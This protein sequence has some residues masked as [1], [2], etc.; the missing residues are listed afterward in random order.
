MP[1]NRWARRAVWTAAGVLGLWA[2]TWAAVPPLLKWQAQKI[3]SAQLGRSVTIGQVDFRPWSLELTLRDVAVAG[4]NGAAPQL[5]V[6]RAYVDVAL[7]SLFRLA[8]VID[9]IQVDAPIVRLKHLGNGHYDVDDILAKFAARPPAADTGEPARFALYNIQVQ[10]GQI[11][12]DDQ[13]VGRQ[14]HVRDLQLSVPFISNL[15][16]QRQVQV[17][18]KLAFVAN[19][20]PFDSSAHA[21]PFSD[22]RQ[23]DA[24][25]RFTKLDLAPYLGYLPAGLPIRLEAATL[26][27]DL[28]LG[29]EQTPKPSLR[30]QGGL[31]VSG[32]K[33]KDGQ[34]ADAL[35]FDGLKVQLADVRPLEGKLHLSS[36][37]LTNPHVAVRRD[38]Q[39]RINL[40]VAQP[41]QG[42]SKNIAASAGGEGARGT[43]G[44][45]ST[46]VAAAASAGSAPA[47]VVPPA[48]AS[49]ARASGASGAASAAPRSSGKSAAP[50]WQVQVDSVT[51]RGGSV[52]VT[53]E[54]TLT[55]LAPA[56]TVRL[57][58]VAL[59]AQR[60]VWPMAQPVAFNGSAAFV[61]TEGLTQALPQ[62]GAAGKT[63]S[64]KATVA[65]ATGAK[66]A[67]KSGGQA[68]SAAGTKSGAQASPASASASSASSA[69]ATT[70]AATAPSGAPVHASAL[71]AVPSLEFQGT[72]SLQGAEVNARVAAL[73][74]ALA[75]P[76]LAPHLVPRLSGN[77]DAH[78]GLQWAP[79]KAQ[80]LPADI[81][82][83]ADRLVLSHLLLADDPAAAA[84]S[85]AAAPA[86]PGR[87]ARPRAPGQLASVGELALDQVLVDL[88]SRAVTV[89]KVALQAP[90]IDV[91]RDADQHLMFERWL[92]QPTGPASATAPKP[93][94][95]PAPSKAPHS[96]FPWKVQ[97]AELMVDDGNVG[98]L[99]QATISPVRAELSQL[100][101]SAKQ[102]DLN[103]AKPMQVALVTRVGAG[104][105]EPGRLSWRGQIGLQP[106]VS[107]QGE[108]D[109]VRLPL[110]A[111]DPYFGDALNIDILRADTSFK[112]NVSFT[113][114]AQG[115]RARVS[116]DALV[117]E[118][119]TYSV[120]GTAASGDT[121]P[122]AAAGTP[123]STTH[124]NLGGSTTTTATA[125][126]TPA[127]PATPAAGTTSTATAKARNGATTSATSAATSA[128]ANAGNANHPSAS[129]AP[130]APMS[131]SAT[132]RAGGLGEEFASWKQL[133]LGG[134][135]VQLEPGKPTQVDVKD[136]QLTDFYAR[137]ILHPNGRLNLQD[138]VKSKDGA[139]A[140]APA[141]AASA[142]SGAAAASAPASGAGQTAAGE[143]SGS[144]ITKVAASAG[145]A[146][147]AAPSAQAADPNAAVI[148]FGPVKLANG[149]VF[150]SDR[151]IRPNYSAD[152]TELNGSLSAFS[153][154]APGG[155][156][157][158]ADLE[159]TGRAEGTAG[160]DIRGKL[161][162]LAKPLALDIKAKVTDLELPPLSPYAVKYAG[163]G[164]ERG[165]LSMDVAYVVQ[166]DGRLTATNKLVLNQLEFGEA[167]AGAPA[168]LPVQLATTLLADSK[169]VIDLD[170]PISGSL[171]DP[172]FSIGPII[173]KAIV[174]IIGKA[175]TAPFT[176]LARAL[177]GGPGD[178]MSYVAF[179]PGSSE[180][181]AKSREQLDKIA[182]ALTDR[183]ALK[184]TVVGTSSLAAEREGYQRERL[185]ALV[186]AEKRANQGAA[187]AA[188][189]QGA[190]ESVAAKASSPAS[191]A[192]AASA[193]TSAASV[194]A[195][196]NAVSDAEYPQLLR[197]LYRRAD[198]PGKPRNAIG[199]Q[200]DIPVAEMEARLMAQ[201][202]V[203]EDAMRQLATQRGV[204]VKDYLAARKLPA[205][206]L[207]L[208]AA[209]SGAQ[210]ARG[211][212]S[213][214]SAP[215]AAASS[216]P[217][218]DGEGAGPWS[219]RAELNLSAR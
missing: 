20:T 176:L 149:K 84:K 79:P 5:Q 169:G 9:A 127:T 174:N 94:P 14:H 60:V 136:T 13:T 144:A 39:G 162:P 182:K 120:P 183:P 6:Q 53:D 98:W 108:V 114:T 219:P 126:A 130:L 172:Q 65:K 163:H 106:A 21:L 58:E 164:I 207:F 205:D 38:K 34:G 146:S 16:S 153:S 40:L 195:S 165:K 2:V 63:A 73:P 209:R 71:G 26:D 218:A 178:D 103:A 18:P 80:D 171:N 179:A 141:G 191:A 117:E 76:Y 33:A 7:Q 64:E 170:L 139:A 122:T 189:A 66:A 128:K 180:L 24:A 168:S 133:R 100:H 216:A 137:L 175:I 151:F 87:A 89:G 145:A 113:Q 49:A 37:E 152:L 154:V 92:R 74:L 91:A 210:P 42:A 143:G 41:A 3:A 44:A 159:L 211:A 215:E 8:P 201:I 101:L 115:P 55:E 45:S 15:P 77:L 213:A 57:N 62:G 181:N 157:Q 59:N 93:E 88:R 69:A 173:V 202:D 132:G 104:R 35:A 186:A 72:A 206:R 203:T 177:G 193:P 129:H 50:V 19:G 187:P 161:N 119:R 85:A 124:R 150:F 10:G 61:G 30:V 56:A 17:Q 32:L 160:L 12:F 112:G 110:H 83:A 212:A 99:D 123:P 97:V 196:P 29:F 155:A 90:Q 43:N 208:G 81:K 118:L 148:H 86:R 185:K 111:L 204:A 28:R 4:A 96:D 52:D 184:L 116:G 140:S 23:T 27:A 95:K 48:S 31:E 217:G 147:A 138:V 166:P 78:V 102:I 158:M 11:D 105:T 82:V 36:V 197:R 131:A 47:A 54:T 142:A 107:A 68:D 51:V 22:S 156:P 188:P 214:A 134:V 190:S 167:V 1:A 199:L 135:D 125:P 200:K 70:K 121:E 198:L 46:A 67:G 109:A 192:T 75:A 194:P 25:F